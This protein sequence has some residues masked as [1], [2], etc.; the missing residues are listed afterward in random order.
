M[1]D[2]MRDKA[3]PNGQPSAWVT[4]H[5]EGAPQHQIVADIACGSSRHTR[6]ALSAGFKVHAIDRDTSKL[7]DIVDNKSLTITETDL[8][9]GSPFPLGQNSI[10]CVIVTNYLHR[11]ILADIVSCL[12]DDGLLVYET[13][14]VGNERHGRPSNP[15]FLLKPGE[16]I[17]ATSA[18]LIP[19][20]YQHT[21]LADPIRVVARLAAV[22]PAHKWVNDPPRL[23]L[24]F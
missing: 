4:A 11:P 7:S 16:L 15:D 6:L 8:E 12:R 13:F 5:L 14:A 24:P 21:M 20:H 19:I 10:G 2:H 3:F 17:D 23:G 9:D 18:R 1:A 22:G